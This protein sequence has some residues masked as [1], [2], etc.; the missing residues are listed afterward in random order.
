M[1][2]METYMGTKVNNW[3]AGFKKR[4][5]KQ[6]RFL[7]AKYCA[8]ILSAEQNDHSVDNIDAATA[9]Y[10]RRCVSEAIDVEKFVM[11]Y[12][13]PQVDKPPLSSADV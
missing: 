6:M 7:R 1:R 12:Q 9:N 13:P 4:S 10:K 2:H 3:D 11:N 5:K 8:A